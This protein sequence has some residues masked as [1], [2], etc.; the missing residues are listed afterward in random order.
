MAPLEPQ[1]DG[2]VA[3]GGRGVLAKWAREL[4]T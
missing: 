4:Q 2:L 1:L 3:K